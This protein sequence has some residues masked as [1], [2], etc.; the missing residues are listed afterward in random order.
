MNT[1]IKRKSPIIVYPYAGSVFYQDLGRRLAKACEEKSTP[2]NLC[3]SAEF[4]DMDATGLQDTT[5][6]IVNPWECV[7][8]LAAKSKFYDQLSKSGKRVMVL[9]EAVGFKWFDAQFQLPIVY[10]SLIDVGF[11]SQE[12]MLEEG[13]LPYSFLFHGLTH[14]EE[15]KVSRI[16]SFGRPIPWAFVGHRRDDRIQVAT[17]LMEMVDPSG[18]VFIPNTGQGIREGK[19]MIGPSGMSLSLARTQCYVWRSLHDLRYYESFRF[20][21][22]ILAGAAPCKIDPEIQWEDYDIPGIFGSVEEFA[23]TLKANGFETLQEK[24]KDFYISGGRLAD[25]L[26][27]VFA[28]V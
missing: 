15:E 20:R 14:E 7:H 24:A 26:E 1:E 12:A 28:S 13:S 4:R 19:G 25:H 22:A 17:E 23:E 16:S 3:C 8:E 21:E 27:E 9:A 2:V 6:F 5:V 11:T 18:L 10:D